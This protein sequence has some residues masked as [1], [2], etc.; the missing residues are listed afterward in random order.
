MLS[1]LTPEWIDALDRAASAAPELT[2]LTKGVVLVIEQEI[3]GPDGI[4]TT[5]HVAIDDGSVSVRPG[6]AEA[7]TIRFIEDRDTAWAVATGE[8]SAQRAF[9]TGRLRVGGDLTV[10][11]AHTEVL[12]A[13]G[14]VFA[15]VRDD[16]EL[17][18][19]GA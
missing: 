5:Y 11:L 12:A 18:A 16:T 15:A 9:M 10:L 4:A 2:A 3:T 19:V 14:D 17:G 6:P 1:F 7:P 13:L 8:L